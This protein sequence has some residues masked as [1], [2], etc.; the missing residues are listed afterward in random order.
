MSQKPGCSALNRL[1]IVWVQRGPLRPWDG[2]A[3]VQG[4]NFRD[5]AKGELDVP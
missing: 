4:R 2:G 3:G 1:C 5:P